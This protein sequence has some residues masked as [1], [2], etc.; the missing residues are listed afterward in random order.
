MSV[1]ASTAAAAPDDLG[2]P[3]ER[4]EP[5]G[6]PPGPLGFG[7]LRG[8]A[9]DDGPDHLVVGHPRLE[10]HSRLRA[11]MPGNQARAGRTTSH[12]ACSEARDRGAS[13]S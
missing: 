6:A 11:P 4:R 10:Q 9:R 2:Q 13:N 5:E 8:V 7:D 1:A 3:T 12:N